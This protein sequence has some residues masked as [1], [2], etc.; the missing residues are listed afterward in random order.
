MAF[1][2]FVGRL[3]ADGVAVLCA[4][5]P[6]S[7]A[8]APAAGCPVVTYGIDL[9]G[10]DW[11]AVDVE[12]GP[13]GSSC[14]VV[15]GGVALGRLELPRPGRHVLLNALG[16]IAAAA[17]AGAGFD[18][19]VRA[20]SA[21]AGV[22]R[23]FQRRGEAGGVTVIDDYAHHPTEVA[24]TVAEARLGGWAR[25]VAAFQPHLYSRTAAFAAEF[26]EALAGADVVVVADVYA[27]REDPVPGVTGALVAE[28]AAAARPGLAVV[29]EPDRAALA[30]RTAGL[31]RPGD[32]LLTLGAGDVT[33]LPDEILPLLDAPPSGD[34]GGAAPRV[35]SGAAP[36][37]EARP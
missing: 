37:P 9:A 36:A 17:A 11:H 18:A 19:A 8:L 6:G 23:R 34:A 31:L 14:T 10:A 32:L 26:G 21:Y 12:A 4:D 7:L 15:R 5:D 28:A 30:A 22:A 33:R 13:A 24:A 35:A 25:V 1:R 29:Y 20:L 3:P 2:H 27:A 16:A